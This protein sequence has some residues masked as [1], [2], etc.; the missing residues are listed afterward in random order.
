MVSYIPIIIEIREQ[1][2]KEW[3]NE[4]FINR[5]TKD[6]QAITLEF[7]PHRKGEALLVNNAADY[8]AFL[9][10]VQF[11]SKVKLKNDLY[12]MPFVTVLENLITRIKIV[13][14]FM[15]NIDQ[16]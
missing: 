2:E 4:L 13:K 14:K 6:L 8:A 7:V 9:D 1:A 5:V 16:L 3:Q 12:I 15:I 11:N 10:E